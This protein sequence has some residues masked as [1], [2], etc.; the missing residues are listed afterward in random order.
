VG[1][2][3]SGTVAVKNGQGIVLQGPGN[4]I[5]GTVAGAGNVI[6]GNFDHGIAISSSQNLVQGNFIGVNAT[7]T[8]ALANRVGIA[9][10]IGVENIIG[11]AIAAARNIISGNT[12]DG[13]KLFRAGAGNQLL[14]NL[15][16]TDVSGTVRLAN[17]QNGVIINESAGVIVG[18]AAPGSANLISGN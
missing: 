13:V 12:E 17:G 8:A 5:G 10:G 2:N 1:T 3:P 16:G 4:T 14:G 9:I 7:G 11:G 6:S 18:G 15:I